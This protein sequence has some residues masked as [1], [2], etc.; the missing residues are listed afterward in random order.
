MKLLERVQ[1]MLPVLNVDDPH[2]VHEYMDSLFIIDYSTIPVTYNQ[3][4]IAAFLEMAGD[5][6]RPP[7]MARRIGVSP[8]AWERYMAAHPRILAQITQKELEC[9][10]YYAKCLKAAAKEGNVTAIKYGLE[11][12]SGGWSSNP[13]PLLEVDEDETPRVNINIS[14]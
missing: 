1:Q 14:Q 2:S 12:G 4:V 5:G 6:L 3:E 9:E 13:A 10:Q 7:S 11:N 8:R